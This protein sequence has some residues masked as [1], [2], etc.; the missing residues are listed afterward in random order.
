MAFQQKA[1]MWVHAVWIHGG[2]TNQ[3][4]LSDLEQEK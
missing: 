2:G 4:A 1:G 3:A